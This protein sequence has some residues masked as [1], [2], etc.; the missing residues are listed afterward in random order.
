[1]D[2]RRTARRR[3][4]PPATV[5]SQPEVFHNQTEAFEERGRFETPPSAR[6]PRLSSTYDHAKSLFHVRPTFAPRRRCRHNAAAAVMLSTPCGV[7]EFFT[8][9]LRESEDIR[10]SHY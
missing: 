2:S 10:R 1:M 5:Y 3:A 9:G 7:F 8:F 6:T 4:P